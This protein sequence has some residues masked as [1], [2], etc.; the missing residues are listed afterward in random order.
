[1]ETSAVQTSTTEPSTLLKA[2]TPARKSS[3]SEH[4]LAAGI[5][6]IPITRTELRIPTQPIKIEVDTPT[7]WL[8][9]V[10]TPVVIGLA[11]AYIAWLN[12]RN[13]IHSAQLLQDN[14]IRSATALQKIQVRSS[15]ANFRQSWST[16]FRTFVAEYVSCATRLDFKNYATPGYVHTPDADDLLTRMATARASIRMML[17]TDKPYTKQISDIMD[18]IGDALFDAHPTQPRSPTPYIAQFVDTAQM[19]RELAWRD[20]KRD[21]SHR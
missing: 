2:D 4:Q 13:S 5:I 18:E 20:I 1:M 16:D 15:I 21:L 12:Q 6:P 17:D 3:V 11:A 19:V 9:A 10:V 7:D 8:A 14:S